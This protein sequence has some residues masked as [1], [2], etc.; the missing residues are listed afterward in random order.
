MYSKGC[1]QDSLSYL[2][3]FSGTK[4]LEAK[5]FYNDDWY[6]YIKTTLAPGKYGL[7]YEPTWGT[8]NVKDFTLK[9][10]AK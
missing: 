8:G 1:Y 9:A 6:S 2:I 5:Y 3:L 4:Y 7:Y 10:Y